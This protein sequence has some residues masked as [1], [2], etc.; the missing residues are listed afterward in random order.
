MENLLKSSGGAEG[1]E[2]VLARYQ[3]VT[4][5]L[6][7]K[8]VSRLSLSLSA[9]RSSLMNRIILTMIF[10]RR[11]LRKPNYAEAAQGYAE[12]A[13]RVRREQ[14]SGS[15]SSSA[16]ASAPEERLL[17]AH[18]LHA[19]ARAH[20]ALQH[21]L[22]EGRALHHSA[23]L[24]LTAHLGDADAQV[25]EAS[26]RSVK[27][28]VQCYEGSELHTMSASALHT[29]SALS[30]TH[31]LSERAQWERDAAES[32]QQAGCTMLAL[33]HMTSALELSVRGHDWQNAHDDAQWLLKLSTELAH[34]SQSDH[35]FDTRSWVL[36]LIVLL[37]VLLDDAASAR[38]NITL[39]QRHLTPTTTRPTVS[40][41]SPGPTLAAQPTLTHGSA[42]ETSKTIA[43]E[44]D[45]SWLNDAA[46]D[47]SSAVRLCGAL[48]A[49]VHACEVGH[50][51]A[52]LL[53][54]EELL[55][56]VA[57]SPVLDLLVDALVD[58]VHNNFAFIL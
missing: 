28:A 1:N 22:L 42:S 5:R 39:L 53:A 44:E 36:L 4:D 52:L 41:A 27:R 25:E 40:V 17:L 3:V 23:S 35:Y 37:N 50:E 9:T 16:S 45:L 46:L 11:F 34:E 8:C 7:R 2:S 48:S 58:Y 10:C 15:G 24:M 14:A 55:T 33:L 20:G 12:L 26:A 32:V 21:T 56:F 31:S 51:S 13:Q 38:L 18:V 54:I 43:E 57:P 29:L 6:K 30:H 47:G 19:Q 49:V